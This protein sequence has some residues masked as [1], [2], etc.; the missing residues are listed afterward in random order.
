MRFKAGRIVL[1]TPALAATEPIPAFAA[2]APTTAPLIPTQIYPMPAVPHTCRQSRQRDEQQLYAF[3]KQNN[4]AEVRRLLQKEGLDV[5]GGGEDGFTPLMTAAEAGHL[6]VVRALA[7]RSNLNKQNAYG[8]TALSFAAQENRVE[9]V[10]ALLEARG[11]TGEVDV[12]M[13]C[14]TAGTAA[15]VARNAS[16]HLLADMLA[17]AMTDKHIT[18]LMLLLRHGAASGDFD[19][20]D[21]RLEAVRDG[22]GMPVQQEPEEVEVEK[23]PECII[24]MEAE[25][26][27]VLA[28]CFHAK[29]C[30]ACTSSLSTCAVCRVPVA[31]VHRIYL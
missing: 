26:D 1:P 24:C 11:R 8:Q 12:D 25:V 13:K 21:A 4:L 28:P 15:T 19:S 7:P 23:R 22:L 6:D 3:A 9:V 31:S 14:G 20:M 5:D 30:H 16:H 10:L 29:Y 17:G 18:K 27:T 2:A